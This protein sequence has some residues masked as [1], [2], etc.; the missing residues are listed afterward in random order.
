MIKY[1]FIDNYKSLVN[2]KIEFNRIDILLGKTAVERVQF[3]R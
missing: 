3:L 1:I 2:F